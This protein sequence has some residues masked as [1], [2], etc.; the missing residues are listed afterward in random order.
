MTEK[1]DQDL[2][3]AFHLLFDVK[4]SVRPV[5]ARYALYEAIDKVKEAM[6]ALGYVIPRRFDGDGR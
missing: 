2:T 5:A 6:R 4:D 1:N 3:E